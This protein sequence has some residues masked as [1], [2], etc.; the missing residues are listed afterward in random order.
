MIF[1]CFLSLESIESRNVKILLSHLCISYIHVCI[2]FV[3]NHWWYSVF[4]VYDIFVLHQG[5]VV[6]GSALIESICKVHLATVQIHS[7]LASLMSAAIIKSIDNWV[8]FRNVS[9]I[10]LPVSHHLW[11]VK[12]L[13]CLKKLFFILQFSIFFFQSINYFSILLLSLQILLFHLLQLLKLWV[14]IIVS[15]LIT[16]SYLQQND[17]V[18]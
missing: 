3:W 5:T 14:F 16:L 10:I 8:S 9:V 7:A 11:F 15:R 17:L 6:A 13:C 1:S 4:S 18:S 2:L 12:V